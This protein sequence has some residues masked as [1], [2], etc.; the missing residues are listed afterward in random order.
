MSGFFQFFIRRLLFIPITLLIITL[1]LYGIAALAPIEV[2]AKL[3]WPPGASEQWMML[4]DPEEVARL[5]QQV[6]K[7]YGLDDPFLIQYGRWIKNL[8]QGDWGASFS[9]NEVLPA[10]THRAPVTI[11]LTL[12]SVLLLIPLGLASGVIAGWRKDQPPDHTFRLFA[13]LG[14]S[15]PPFIL[16]L[17]LLMFFYVIWNF[18]PPGRTSIQTGLEISSSTSDFKSFTG[19]IT[20]D[21]ILNGRP[22]IALDAL[23][24]LVLPVITLSLAH[25]ATLGRVTRASMI[26]EMDQQYITA[27]RGRGLSNREAAWRHALRNAVL[28]GMNSIAVSIAAL[29]TGVFVI[30][31]VFNFSGISEL[32]VLAVSQF[33]LALTL[34]LTIYSVLIVLPTMFI[35]DILQAVV[36]PRIRE[37]GF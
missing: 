7:Q 15:I 8:M 35:L 9:V 21:G 14:T 11:E 6:I 27:A 29:I 4:A 16:G 20:I 24:H 13:F 23:R 2:R 36:D 5:N 30:E 1:V 33:D 32:I 22:D 18:F 19:L 25:W 12:Y 34:G 28:P 10:I 17:L 3:Y 26:D 37:G 31:T